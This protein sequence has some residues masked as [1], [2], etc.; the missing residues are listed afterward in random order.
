MDK[1]FV[2]EELIEVEYKGDP[3]LI[4]GELQFAFVA[5]LMGQSYESFEAW[6]NLISILCQ[7]DDALNKYPDL[8][9][10]F[11][12]VFLVQLMDVPED[13]FIDE[14]S[15]GGKNFIREML[16]VSYF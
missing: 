4:L 15:G 13:F 3:N 2:L 12:K 6:K 11:T 9:I 16:K 1:S 10:N 14:I 5:F 7:C 8:F